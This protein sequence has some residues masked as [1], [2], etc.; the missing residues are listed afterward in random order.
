MG[1]HF[2]IK[3]D[4][5]PLKILF[6]QKV[7]TPSQY[8]WLAKLMAYDYKIQYKKGK[9]NFVADALLRVNG[10]EV[11]VQALSIISTE[12]FDKIKAS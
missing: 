3:T 7:M 2:I 12:I 1:K 8:T 11:V 6:D 5:K 4:H 9:L 10:S